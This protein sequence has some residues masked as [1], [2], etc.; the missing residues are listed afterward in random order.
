MQ[1]F[2][3]SAILHLRILSYQLTKAVRWQCHRAR[4]GGGAG[5]EASAPLPPTFL[6]IVKS[7]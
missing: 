1:I 6:K 7:Y 4:G 2:S 5:G 3:E